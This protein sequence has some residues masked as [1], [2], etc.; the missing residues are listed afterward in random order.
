MGHKVTLRR[1][2]GETEML[3]RYSSH[4][5]AKAHLSEYLQDA[6]GEWEISDAGHRAEAENGRRLTIT[7]IRSDH[8]NPGHVDD[9]PR[10][11]V[12]NWL[13]R[14]TEVEGL[15]VVQND[16]T[17]IGDESVPRG[18]LGL[19]CDPDEE[20][21]GYLD[22]WKRG[23]RDVP[24]YYS[25][26]PEGRH[27]TLLEGERDELPNRR[28]ESAS[29]RPTPVKFAIR[30]LNGMGRY[31]ESEFTIHDCLP[32]PCIVEREKVGAIAVAPR[33][34]DIDEGGDD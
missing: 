10:H 30:G 25:R 12:M 4:S 31:P 8:L 24:K 6:G 5:D 18:V 22:T 32:F 33:V 23:E 29:I 26:F 27:A 11:G 28:Y 16:N 34:K 7:P 20:L 2:D 9:D 17:K 15:R 13:D 14:R 1:E 3:A 21:S 19:V